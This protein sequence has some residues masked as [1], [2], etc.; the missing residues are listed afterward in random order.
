MADVSGGRIIWNLDVNDKAFNSQ[1]ARAGAA[2]GTFAKGLEGSFASVAQF[3]GKASNA[4]NNVADGISGLASKFKIAGLLAGL[5]LGAMAKSSLD[6]VR[7]VQRSTLAL[8]AYTGSAKTAANITKQMIAF[9]KSDRGVLFNRDELLRST[10]L[11]KG[12]GL[13]TK[14]LTG[15]IKSM[16]PAVAASGESFDTI[17]EILADVISTGKLGAEQFDQLARRGIVL[18]KSLQGTSVS[19]AQLQKALEKAVPASI[20]DKQAQTVDGRITRLKTSFREL[21]NELLGVKYG[22]NEFGATFAPGSLGDTAIKALEQLTTA[23]KSK[24]FKQGIAEAGKAIGDLVSQAIPLL[25]DGLKFVINN[26][27]KIIFVLKVMAA[28]WLAAKASALAFKG[29][30]LVSTFA[31]MSSGINGVTQSLQAFNAVALALSIAMGLIITKAM[32]LDQTLAQTKASTKGLDD[33][34]AKMNARIAASKTD[35]ERAKWVA[36]RAELQRSKAE[37]LALTERYAGLGGKVNAVIDYIGN[38]GATLLTSSGLIGTFSRTL[39]DLSIVA[40]KVGRAFHLVPDSVVVDLERLRTS[41]DK[42]MSEV[43]Q[44]AGAKAAKVPGTVAAALSP[45][46]R[47][48]AAAVAPTKD[49]VA[50]ALSPT[51]GAGARSAGKTPGSVHSALAPTPSKAAAAVRPTSGRVSGELNKLGPAGSRGGN[52]LTRSLASAISSGAG[53]PIFAVAALVARI[54]AKLPHSDADEGP[55]SDL[56]ASGVALPTT[57]AKGIRRGSG[58]AIGAAASMVRGIAYS[59]GV[60]GVNVSS[61]IVSAGGGGAVSI[62]LNMSGVMTRSRNDQRAVAKDML[63]AVN[64]EL[65]VRNVPELGGGMLN[66]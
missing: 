46:A 16:A 27:D 10:V 54:R 26:V 31:D 39:L 19:A 20:L 41:V 48:G 8:S 3:S 22:A 23:F 66:A 57:L 24:D 25:I 15:F 52:A 44:A 33:Q 14:R 6:M 61:G 43:N 13:E 29:V 9:A 5:A 55:L 28:A 38:F 63:E 1:L 34:I 47:R 45:T 37:T 32:S 58:T 51:A 36:L 53:G 40:A 42:K 49:W 50:R 2:A 35:A 65:R 56:F 21:G 59:S 4:F 62:H 30:E 11:L 12:A 60:G 18:D 17:A 64:E 7:S